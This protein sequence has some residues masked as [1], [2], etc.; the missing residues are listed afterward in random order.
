[1]SFSYGKRG[2]VVLS[3]LGL[4][5]LPRYGFRIQCISDILLGPY[6]RCRQLLHVNGI[7][8]VTTGFSRCVTGRPGID[9]QSNHCFI[10][11]NRG[12]VRTQGAY[13][14]KHSL[15]VHY[16]IFCNLSGRRRTLLFTIR[17]NVSDRLATNRRLHTGL[18]TRRRG[19]YS[20]TTMAR[21]ANM[22]FT[23]SKVHTP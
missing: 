22:H 3:G 17:A 9:C 21:G 4:S 8:G 5:D 10:F 15:P 19:T 2:T 14:N 13:G 12:A 7:T 11:S 1:M 20:F 16:G 6:T 18:I 23:L